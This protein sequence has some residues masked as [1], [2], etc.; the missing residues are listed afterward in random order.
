MSS[1][2]QPWRRVQGHPALIAA[3]ASVAL[4]L[5]AASCSGGGHPPG[6]TARGHAHAPSSPAATAGSTSTSGAP[7]PSSSPTP[8]ASTASPSTTALSWHGCGGSFQCATLPVPLDYANPKAGTVDLALV[9]LPASD[10]AHRVG[11]LLVN[12]GGPGASG[13]DFVRQ[14]SSLFSPAL[15]AHFDI[16]GFDPRGVGRSDPVR[17]ENGQALASY[18]DLEPA[19]STASGVQALVAASRELAKDCAARS[20]KALLA[21]VATVDA[22]RDMDR[23]RA[24][25]HDAKLSYL[26]FSYGTFLGATYANLFPTHVRAMA[27]D[28]ALDPTLTTEQLDLQ[29][30]KGFELDLHDF[31]AHCQS[32][33]SCPLLG[34]AAG[35]SASPAGSSASPAGS[36]AGAAFDRALARIRSGPPL[37]TGPGSA[38]TLGPGE[39]YL[40]IIA[41]LY[42]ESTWPVLAAGLAQVLQ[43]DGYILLSLSDAYTQRQPNGTYSNELAANTAINCV[44]R[45][46]PTDLATYRADAARFARAA[47]VFGVLEAYSALT[48]AYWPVPPTGHP[49]PLT[50]KGAPP[51][52]VVGTTAD[53]ATPYA[54]AQ[55][56]AH[57]LS[58]A[59]L[60]THVG[61]GHTAYGDSACVRQAV[62]AYLIDLTVPKP[63]LVCHS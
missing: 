29:Q 28:G 26:G 31:L 17:C 63:G 49:H 59:V 51:I 2:G 54:W 48:C 22:A 45:P 33:P 9:R 42:S 1:S 40:G 44:D 15:R 55:A 10:P 5:G 37:P 50:A 12:P 24:A 57:Q 14:Q 36:S 60:V 13:V 27:L 41:A 11:D 52:V 21:R 46:S 25:L 47:P 7:A 61:V 43:G 19:P 53:P 56:L 20:G 18:I 4:A 38:R 39:G 32:D 62:D 8:S 58:S 30:A 6:A 34:A 16:V 3:A 23:I 35:S